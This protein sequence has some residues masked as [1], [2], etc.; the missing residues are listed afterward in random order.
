MKYL[1]LSAKEQK[2]PFQERRKLLALLSDPWWRLENLY[3]IVNKQGKLVR[4]LLRPEQRDLLENA[5]G[6]DIILKARQL[7]FSTA[8]DIWMLDQ[9]IFIPHINCGI[10]AQDRQSSGEIF[11]TK[12]ETP[13]NNL[14]GWLKPAVKIVRR[15][16][17]STGGRV[18]FAHGSTIAVATSF[19]SGTVHCLHVSEHGKICA[20]YPAKAQ[21]LRTGTLPAVPADGRIWIESTAEG[22]GGDFHLMCSNAQ[23]AAASGLELSPLAFKFHF[24]AWW[25]HSEYRMPVPAGDPDLSILTAGQRKY[26]STVEE[27]TGTLLSGEQINWYLHTEKTQR[28]E[29]RQ[30]Y[31]STP[32]EAFL[33]SGRRVFAASDTLA[34]AASLRPPLIV[35]EMEPVSGKRTKVQTTRDKSK[36]LTDLL[37]VWEL[38]GEDDHYAIGADVAEGLEHG[39]YSSLDIVKQSTGEQVAHWYGK[40]DTTLFASLLVHLGT[41]YNMAYLVPERNN[42]GHAVLAY[43][44]EH[45]PVTRIHTE[46]YLDRDRENEETP[47]LG[48]LT[49]RHSKPILTEGLKDLLRDRKSGIRW[50]GTLTELESFV[51]HPSGSMGAQTG[52][53][54]D[55]VMSYMLAQEGRVTMPKTVKH[56]PQEHTEAR[57]WMTY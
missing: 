24:Y 18:E 5:H 26:F 2:N 10:M 13:L 22:V 52:C 34:A 1:N 9:A 3:H 11:R 55:Q 56:K 21:E 27:A 15:Q 29:M 35:C 30:E 12:I 6:R 25:Q 4:F 33:T 8:I 36:P 47:R 16:G 32:G 44:R 41:W 28:D 14:P 53:Y 7:G 37:L 40:T 45:Y 38:P 43:L 31:P 23:E 49:T 20:K 17:G 54:D 50:R 39:D 57:H 51:Y 19:R 48:W 42:H 46:H